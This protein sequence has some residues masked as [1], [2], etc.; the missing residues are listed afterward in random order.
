MGIGNVRGKAIAS[1]GAGG[2]FNR[3][4]LAWLAQ[5]GTLLAD[6][7]RASEPAG[8]SSEPEGLTASGGYTTDWVSAPGDVYRTHIFETS[9][10]FEVTAAGSHGNNL[11]FLVVGGGGGGAYEINPGGGG[12]GAGGAG[13]LRTNAAPAHPE[14]MP[15]TALV[16]PGSGTWTCPIT[17]GAGGHE[18]LN[19]PGK[20]GNYSRITNPSPNPNITASG[21]GGGSHS[22]GTAANPG[23]SGGGGA[24]SSPS[25]AASTVAAPDGTPTVQGY[26]GNIGGPSSNG[27]GGG[28]GAGGNAFPVPTEHAGSNGGR[29][30]SVEIAGPPSSSP[31]GREGPD[32]AVNWFAGGGGGGGGYPGGAKPGGIGGAG[33]TDYPIPG[34]QATP[35]CGGGNGNNTPVNPGGPTTGDA[36]SG[37]YGT[38]GGGG[39]GCGNTLG[40]GI[41]GRAGKGGSGIVAIKYKIG[42]TAPTAKATGGAIYYDQSG[43]VGAE[44]WVHTFFKTDTFVTTSAIPSAEYLIIAGGGAGGGAGPYTYTEGGGGGAGGFKTNQPGNPYA[45]YGSAIAFASSSPYTIT[46]GAGG[47]GKT[48]AGSHA[49]ASTPGSDSSLVHSTGTITAAGGGRGGG[50]PPANTGRTG[51]SGGG[52][53]GDA[54]S[55]GTATPANQGNPGGAQGPAGSSSY[56]AGGGGGGAGGAGSAGGSPGSDHHQ[57]PGGDGLASTISGSSI[58]YAGGGSGGGYDSPQATPAPGGGGIGGSGVADNA[59]N[60]RENSGSGGGGGI[61]VDNATAG[62]GGSGIVVIAYPAA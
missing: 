53:G 1:G 2:S 38:G 8:S 46:V 47:V 30:V 60:G 56:Y 6:P 4:S 26:P 12:R 57:G 22:P 59:T 42:T 48:G 32:G 21:G 25:T 39:G 5:K 31:I 16:Y 44:R 41:N 49:T 45:P 15:S 51:G 20:D 9:G 14:N 54:S 29:G 3:D 33:P 24:Y 10:T 55:G 58:T 36:Q 35:K 11:Q 19:T 7:G 18:A 37:H 52:G 34:T 28:G 61:T 17:V 27:G 62:S 50:N 23:G 13:G 43:G 40:D